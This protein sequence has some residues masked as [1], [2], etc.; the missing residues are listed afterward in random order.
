M[1]VWSFFFSVF[2][3]FASNFSKQI[4]VKHNELA[5]F[6]YYLLLIFKAQR[7]EDEFDSSRLSC[8]RFWQFLTIC[9]LASFWSEFPI[10][11]YYYYIYFGCFLF[12]LSSSLCVIDIDDR[13]TT[14]WKKF[15]IWNIHNNLMI[16]WMECWTTRQQK[17]Y[18]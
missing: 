3:S 5:H 9:G 4:L 13:L 1:F 6:K 10:I 12:R 7:P 16:E 15:N 8:L 18:K 11:I 2:L 17:V 14:E